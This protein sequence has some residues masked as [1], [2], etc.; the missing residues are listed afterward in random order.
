MESFF[1]RWF[2]GRQKFNEGMVDIPCDEKRNL[3][4]QRLPTS[5]REAYVLPNMARLIV[6]TPFT[7][8]HHQTRCL[9]ARGVLTVQLDDVGDVGHPYNHM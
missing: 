8:V 4:N 3:F 1:M 9:L 6:T 5:R 7:R 2:T